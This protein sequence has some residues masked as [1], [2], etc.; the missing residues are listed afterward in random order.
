MSD[1]KKL[2][3]GMQRYSILGL[4][5]VAP[6]GMPDEIL[7]LVAEGMVQSGHVIFDP[8]T[9]TLKPNPDV[10][11]TK[12]QGLTLKVDE[13]GRIASAQKISDEQIKR[14]LGLSDLHISKGNIPDLRKKEDR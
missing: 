11:Q 5:F 9:N 1:E 3:E 7:A 10:D 14:D 13:A 12:V 6:S 2:P 4:N 8:A